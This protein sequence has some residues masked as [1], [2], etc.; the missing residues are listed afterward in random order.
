MGRDHDLHVWAVSDGMPMVTVDVVLHAGNHGTDV[1]A[2][3]ARRL[4]DGRV[5]LGAPGNA[6]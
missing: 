6:G 4:R 5:Q 1:A 3:V 2:A